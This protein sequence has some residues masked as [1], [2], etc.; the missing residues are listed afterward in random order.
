MP[1]VQM[2]IFFSRIALLIDGAARHENVT[3]DIALIT[4]RIR[5]VQTDAKRRSVGIAQLKAKAAQKS[6]EGIAL[7]GV[8]KGAEAIRLPEVAVF[9]PQSTCI[10]L[11]IYSRLVTYSM[12]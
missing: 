12:A 5:V 7:I 2:A 4:L 3:V 6:T 10:G 1:V 8:A 9:P 11:Q